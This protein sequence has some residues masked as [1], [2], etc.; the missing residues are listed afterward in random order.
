M[1]SRLM[2]Y[3][4]KQDKITVI[5]IH[6]GWVQTDMGTE[7]APLT[8]E[9]SIGYMIGAMHQLSPEQSGLFLNYDGQPLPW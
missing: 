9:E 8:T 7:R 3:E 2:A 4:L 5:S 6:P 1:A